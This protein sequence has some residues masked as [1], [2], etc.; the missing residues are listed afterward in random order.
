M[1]GNISKIRKLVL[2]FNQDA[3]GVMID[4]EDFTVH[5]VAG[6]LK[7]FFKSLPDPLL[8]HHLHPVFIGI[9]RKT[10]SFSVRVYMY[11]YTCTYMCEVIF[12]A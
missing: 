3:S 10:C 6:A 4:T 8:T 9:M 5:D 12:I 2:A 7:D 11:A 1:S